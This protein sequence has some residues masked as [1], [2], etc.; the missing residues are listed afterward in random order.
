VRDCAFASNGEFYL[1]WNNASGVREIAKVSPVAGPQRTRHFA[2]LVSGMGT[3]ITL[4]ENGVLAGCDEFGPFTVG[5]RDTLTRYADAT[6]SGSVGSRDVANWHAVACDTINNYLYYIYLSDR[7][8]RRIPLDGYTQTG[9]TEFVVTLDID[10]SDGADGMAVD[11]ADGSLYILVE[12]ANTKSIVRV[13]GGVKT[14]V[15]DFFTRPVVGTRD[16]ADKAGEQTH[17]TT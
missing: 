10:E 9:P 7:S 14:T 16:P 2:T 3:E 11:H 17:S 12:S 1:A 6:Y 13:A 15:F 8:L 4:M 5:C